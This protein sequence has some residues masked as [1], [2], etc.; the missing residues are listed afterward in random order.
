[1]DQETRYYRPYKAGLPDLRSYSRDIWRRRDFVSELARSELKAEHST[2]TLGQLW[3][4]LNPL[5]LA[6]IYYLLVVMISKGTSRG[7]GYFTHLLAGLFAFQFFSLATAGATG[8]VSR[9]AG[10][11]TNLAFPRLVLPIASIISALRRFI[12][13]LAVYFAFH[14]A[15]HQPLGM[16]TLAIFPAFALLFVFTTGFAFLL[17]TVNVY[18]RDAKSFLP[19][20]MRLWLYISPV[21]YMR[22]AVSGKYAMLSWLNPLFGI[23]TAWG[24]A[25]S[26]ST[27][28]SPRDWILATVWSFSMLLFG[29]YM[30][31]S[32]ERD[33]SV[34]L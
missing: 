4:V 28:A 32:R 14:L 22:E 29:S 6:G 12:P 16:A 2:T 31:L 20:V 7:P 17:A 26:K 19:Y 9:L 8:S 10:L 33:F 15:F 25:L 5:L 1:V 34:R 24:D 21:L 3:I 30:F 18:F 27:V 13:M 23:F 11:I